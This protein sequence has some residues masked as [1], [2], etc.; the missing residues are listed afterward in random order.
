MEDRE[1]LWRD[2]LNAI[3]QELDER[4]C[5]EEIRRIQ[6]AA[7]I[8]ELRTIMRALEAAVDIMEETAEEMR[9]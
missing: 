4:E 8:E 6:I 7:S 3:R 2:D 9:R 1:K 5:T